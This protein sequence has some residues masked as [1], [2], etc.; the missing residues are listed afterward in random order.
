MDAH[1]A[2]VWV[3]SSKMHVVPLQQSK[4]NVVHVESSGRHD[5]SQ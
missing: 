2:V 1:D 4:G 5:P 3:S